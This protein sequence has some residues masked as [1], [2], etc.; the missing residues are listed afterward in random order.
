MFLLSMNWVGFALVVKVNALS[1]SHCWP[2]HSHFWV[3]LLLLTVGPQ[4][5]DSVGHAINFLFVYNLK[6]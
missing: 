3:D 5:D 1:S 2:T 4:L 6:Q